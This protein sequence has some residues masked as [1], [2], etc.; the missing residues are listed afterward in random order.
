MGF[1][2]SPYGEREVAPAKDE[3]DTPSTSDAAQHR[4]TGDDIANLPAADNDNNK[5]VYTFVNIRH[6]HQSSDTARPQDLNQLNK[7]SISRAV[8]PNPAYADGSTQTDEVRS[9]RYVSQGNQTEIIVEEE[10]AFTEKSFHAMPPGPDDLGNSGDKDVV[11]EDRG[12]VR[13][14]WD[15]ARITRVSE[16]L[17]IDYL[18]RMVL[19]NSEPATDDEKYI[20]D[21]WGSMAADIVF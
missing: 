17:G 12:S 4:P 3:D 15:E 18:S 21:W 13:R 11:T 20:V 19:G 14:D 16:S 7:Q 9:M 8:S 1:K 6:V 10:G 5:V 2:K